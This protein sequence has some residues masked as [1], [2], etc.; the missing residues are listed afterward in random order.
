MRGRHGHSVARHLLFVMFVSSAASADDQ[1]ALPSPLGV[2]DVV[3]IAR[4]RRPEVVAAQA[5]ARAAAERPE[6][7]SALDDPTVLPSIDHLPFALGGANVSLTVEQRFPL[8]HVRAHRRDAAE[9]DARR[10]VAEIDRVGLDVE[11]DAATAFWMLAETRAVAKIL[12]EQR[13]LAD[14]VTKAATARYSASTGPQADVLR[15]RLEVDRLDGERQAFVAEIR[16]A[17][18]MLDT[19]LARS[20]DATIPE[21]DATV[22][23]AEPPRAA[24][25]MTA[26]VDRRPEL[27]AD[28]AGIARSEADLEVMHSMYV[29][30]ASVRTGPNYMMTDGAGWML[31]V[32]ITIP[33]WRG[34]LRAGVAE[35]TATVAM[36]NAELDATQRTIVGEAVVG[37]ERVEA[38][39][40][41]YLAL[42]DDILPR[43]TEV[44]TS[45]LAAYSADQLPLVSAIDA[46]RALWSTQRELIEAQAELGLAWARLQRTTGDAR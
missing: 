19:S 6:I 28:R 7:V 32:G 16:A 31:M 12:D 11:L 2:A 43:A 23:D 39:R 8:S 22:T 15:A 4:A 30:M 5:R 26:A 25:V 33:L 10:E 14:Q 42:R 17:E 37:R 44:V 21:L 20:P 41:R 36:A 3:R 24:A 9:A 38:A 29:P 40:A 46:A 13:A 27:R 1:V 34:K 45:T 35:A 18:A